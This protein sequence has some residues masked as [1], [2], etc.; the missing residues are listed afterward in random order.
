LLRF[1]LQPTTTKVSFNEN[2]RVSVSPRYHRLL[3]DR[4]LPDGGLANRHLADHRFCL[5]DGLRVRE[6]GGASDSYEG[7]RCARYDQSFHHG[8][9][10]LVSGNK[11]AIC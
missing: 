3:A 1:A 4:A 10:P 5:I 7:K 8:I 6:V 9:F 11:A 2:C